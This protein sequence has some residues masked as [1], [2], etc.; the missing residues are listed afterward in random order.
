MDVSVDADG[1]RDELARLR[2]SMDR[3]RRDVLSVVRDATASSGRRSASPPRLRGAD[4]DADADDATRRDAAVTALASALEAT[5]RADHP[6]QPDQPESPEQPPA[7]EQPEV[8]DQPEAPDSATPGQ[9]AT[10]GVRFGAGLPGSGLVALQN[11]AVTSSLGP[12]A[13][14]ALLLLST[15][16]KKTPAATPTV[17]PLADPSF[18]PN[19]GSGGVSPPPPPPPPP[20]PVLPVS[21][22]ENAVQ[23]NAL[24]VN[25]T[26]AADA[27]LSSTWATVPAPP[28][29]A[30]WTDEELLNA[31]KEL[32]ADVSAVDS[33]PSQPLT[34]PPATAQ[35]QNQPDADPTA[36]LPDDASAPNWSAQARTKAVAVLEAVRKN[37]LIQYALVEVAKRVQMAHKQKQPVA[38]PENGD[39][40]DENFFDAQE[41]PQKEETDVPPVEPAAHVQTLEEAVRAHADV[42]CD[43]AATPDARAQLAEEVTNRIDASLSSQDV[44]SQLKD[45]MERTCKTL[46]LQDAL[47]DA[48]ALRE[49]IARIANS[50]V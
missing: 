48:M 35:Q 5:L 32:D 19:G 20:L 27:M 29:T 3:L 8:P 34:P 25:L 18:Q 36:P 47:A 49:R 12:A 23:A 4:A 40:A 17:Y 42:V 50:I 38:A 28:E 10:T 24:D 41:N 22:L 31:L 7:P 15:L 21:Q 43:A 16:L 37:P 39:A 26:R 2:A 6:P 14:G 44:T 30:T 33:A 9:V 1:V 45:V 46:E 11:N 13:T